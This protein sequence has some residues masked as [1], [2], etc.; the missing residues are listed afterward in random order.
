MA[1]TL[2]EF[3]LSPEIRESTPPPQHPNIRDLRLAQDFE[4]MAEV[5]EV[6]TSVSIGKPNWQT[7]FRVHPDWFGYYPIFAMKQDG[8]RDD[9]YMVDT[10]A[11]PELA[12]EV[13]PRLLVPLITRAGSLYIWA[14][15]IGTP[16]KEADLAATSSFSAM[17]KAKSSWIRLR[18]I[19]REYKCSEPK[20]KLPEPEWP[21]TTFEEMLNLAFADKVID[22]PDHA[23]VK[24]L[25]GEC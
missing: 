4:N 7:Y 11:V 18:W 19:G 23:V 6:V 25:N 9:L 17:K 1:D 10:K 12:P 13:E 21:E 14:L 5:R 22:K 24:A 2:G 3:A 8:K 20:N 16:E 15:R